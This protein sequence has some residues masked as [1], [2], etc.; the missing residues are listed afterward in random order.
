MGSA[1]LLWS[2]WGDA[3]MQKNLV[4][5]LVVALGAA[6]LSTGVFYSLFAERLLQSTKA[7]QRP[8]VAESGPKV[9]PGLRAV[10]VYVSDSTGV[11]SLL[12]PGQR[13]D[14]MVIGGS[15]SRPGTDFELRTVL[16]NVEVLALPSPKEQPANRAGTQAVTLLAKPAEVEMLAL[17]DSAARVRLALRNPLD[18]G[19]QARRRLVLADVFHCCGKAER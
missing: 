17:A 7:P 6:L 5:L 11:L 16:E 12:R 19:T 15:A 3:G 1:R 14:V 13:V 18:H 4:K 2:T 9:P 8:A 10:S